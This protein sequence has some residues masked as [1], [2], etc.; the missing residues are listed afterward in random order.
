[1][2]RVLNFIVWAMTI[3]QL[4]SA[5]DPQPLPVTELAAGTKVEYATVAKILQQ[6][7]LACHSG[8]K[9][10]NGLNME[11]PQQ[12]LKGG[13]SG[14][15]IIAK[16]AK[17]SLI[18]KLAAHTEAP[19]MPPKDNKVNA[20][21]LSP[22][23]LGLLKAWIDQG[24]TGTALSAAATLTWQ[25]V[26]THV[27]PIAATAIT[28]DGSIAAAGRGNQIILVETS[29]ARTLASLIDPSLSSKAGPRGNIAHVDLVQALAFDPTGNLLASGSFREIKLW[30]R[31]TNAKHGDLPAAEAPIKSLTSSS[32]GK[33]AAWGLDQGKVQILDIPSN[34]ILHTLAAHNGPVTGLQFSVDSGTL[35]TAGEDKLL[36]AWKVAD[37][38][39]IAKLETPAPI[40]GLALV[41]EGNQLVTGQTDN[42]IRV[43]PL[44]QSVTEA[45]AKPVAEIPGHKAPLVAIAGTPAGKYIVA[46]DQSNA[47]K[48]WS[49]ESKQQKL[50]YNHGATVTSLAISADGKRVASSSADNSAKVYSIADAKLLSE[51]RGDSRTKF[52]VSKLERSVNLAKAKLEDRKKDVTEAE[53]LAKKEAD[54]VPKAKELKTTAEKARNEKLEATK[55]P[56]EDKAA[57]EKALADQ[58]AKLKT[59]QGTLNDAKLAV[60]KANP[61]DAK[62]VAEAKDKLKQAEAAN[63]TEETALEAAK[64][65]LDDLTK[66]LKKPEE[67][68]KSAELSLQSADRGIEAAETSVKKANEAVESAK[69]LVTAGEAD[70]KSAETALNDGK[71]A[72]TKTEQPIQAIT[73]NNDGTLLTT[74]STDGLVQTWS[75]DTGSPLGVI[76]SGAPA[77]VGMTATVNGILTT[78]D[79][80]S[81]SHWNPAA[82]WTL[83][84]TIGK[85]DDPA[86]LIDRVLALEF[87]PDGKLLASGGG[88]PSRSG[89][90][91]LWNVENGQLAKSF[92]DPH[93][94]TIF[95]VR[96]NNDGT[97]LATGGADRFLK[98]FRVADAGL[99]KA[100][101]GH[102]HHVLAVAWRMDGRILASGSAD[103]TIKVWDLKTGEQRR[104]IQGF[105]KEITSL[106]F[107]ADSPRVI[108]T[109]GDNTVRLTNTDSGGNERS[110][111]GPSDYVLTAAP[112]AD[113]KVFVGGGQDGV[114]RV[115]DTGKIEP[116]RAVDK[117]K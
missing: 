21:N 47:V 8:A 92:T 53:T 35:Y 33:L 6:N 38:S 104:T 70:I 34:K 113:G 60:E 44:P 68:L 109:C 54:A 15:A 24:A 19:V 98:V 76:A 28:P 108:A 50:E 32:D 62:L 112:A 10:E 2:L 106:N 7:C 97:L 84:R 88:E 49:L 57:A 39:E 90:L 31:P 107:L 80:K 78:H 42:M 79:N 82:P 117:Q 73:L 26:P 59:V 85:I 71:A 25:P 74:A 5:A 75:A 87:S 86:Q 20:K 69:Q 27:S 65:K 63:K 101:E 81:L 67:D 30:R 111:T 3:C 66:A 83:E 29:S 93:S 12:M 55:K 51:V 1:M 94:D 22:T 114:L 58:E 13:D 77:I 95:A 36:K 103:N 102:T 37:G 96:F 61:E 9:A 91:K 110:F 46:A 23:D 52:T 100:F 72:A 16:D 64:K 105:N 89:E 116:L 18:F 99:E 48:I 14:P 43:W 17:A 41:S 40:R 11:S 115:W 56:R 45:P 4:A